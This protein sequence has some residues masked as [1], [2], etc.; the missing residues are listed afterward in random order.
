[1]TEP[2]LQIQGTIT[3]IKEPHRFS[4]KFEKQEIVIDTGGKFPQPVAIE[5]V[6]DKISMIEQCKVGDVVNISFNVRGREWTS[7]AG[8]VRHFVSLSGWRIGTGESYQ[9]QTAPSQDSSRDRPE[10]P[11][12]PPMADDDIPF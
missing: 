8:E 11:N 12:G 3:T 7:P 1:M 5:F 10:P 4:E 6:N 2:N 9:E